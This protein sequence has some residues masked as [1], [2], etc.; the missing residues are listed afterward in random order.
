MIKDIVT[1]TKVL[2]QKSKPCFFDELSVLKNKRVIKHLLDTAEHHQPSCLGIAAPQ[3][4]IF[5][6]II[7][8]KLEG[9]LIPMVNPSYTP[10]ASLGKRR[11]QE[12]C[13][14]FPNKIGDNRPIVRRFKKIKLKYHD[15]NGLKKELVLMKLPSAVVQHEIDHLNGKLI[16]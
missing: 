2:K 7:V 3:I 1:D 4:N 13:L 8:V 10:I 14:S 12:S 5:T 11:Y 9:A 16:A 6:R 15:V